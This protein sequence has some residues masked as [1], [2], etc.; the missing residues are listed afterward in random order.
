[1]RLWNTLWRTG[2]LR[3]WPVIF[4]G[5]DD[6]AR[7]SLDM[8]IEMI[9]AA[10]AV[11]V[12][13]VY[14]VAAA[15]DGLDGPQVRQLS[16]VT[17][18]WPVSWLEY[19]SNAGS[20]IA[21]LTLQQPLDRDMAEEF[22]RFPQ[23]SMTLEGRPLGAIAI[24]L[25][26]FAHRS[27]VITIA[28]DEPDQAPVLVGWCFW[29]SDAEGNPVLSETGRAIMLTRTTPAHE[30]AAFIGFA[31]RVA[32]LSYAFAN[33]QNVETIEVLPSRQQRRAAE[34]RG[35]QIQSHYVLTIDANSQR[36]AYPKGQAV[37][38]G[39]RLHIAR[40][41]FATYTEAAPLFGKLVGRFWVPAHVRGRADVGV[42]SKDYRIEAPTG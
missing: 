31:A 5:D 35:E 26:G 6:A 23:E 39:K 18:P 20:P 34:R 24:P 16:G 17:A 28:S 30:H 42:I 11:D 33:C 29:F 37:P 13:A 15:G 32:V 3:T 40:G 2:N 25:E 22:S 4:G 12:N 14:A 38:Q 27:M 9:P 8:V 19:V 36:K 41:H 7:D 10:V 21:M 1:M